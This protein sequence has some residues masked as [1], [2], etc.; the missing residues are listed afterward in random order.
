MRSLP[1]PVP[2][3][4]VALIRMPVSIDGMAAIVRE[5]TAAYGPGLVIRMD[6][7]LAGWTVI[8]RPAN[9]LDTRGEPG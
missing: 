6:V 5:L 9:G 1:L 2:P 7:S 4:T 3:E 8:A